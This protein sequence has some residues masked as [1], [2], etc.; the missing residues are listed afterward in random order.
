[1]KTISLVLSTVVLLASLQVH[2]MDKKAIALKTLPPSYQRAS[3]HTAEVQQLFRVASSTEDGYSNPVVQAIREQKRKSPRLQALLGQ[4]PTVITTQQAIWNQH[5]LIGSADATARIGLGIALVGLINYFVDVLQVTQSNA[6]HLIYPILGAGANLIVTAGATGVTINACTRKSLLM[7]QVE[8]LLET[9]EELDKEIPASTD[10]NIT[11]KRKELCTAHEKIGANSTTSTGLFIGGI[12]L[13][14]LNTGKNVLILLLA[15]GKIPLIA[16]CV[17]AGIAA[18]TV[19]LT[20]KTLLLHAKNK[21]LAETLKLE[22]DQLNSNE[23][24]QE[25]L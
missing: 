24:E 22:L 23:Q 14:T 10:T 1:M 25:D 12:T 9:L 13:C 4:E 18:I 2:C 15:D 3:G 11:Q 19:G 7:Q 8:S 16:E 21:R 17:N 5:E 20:I 6:S